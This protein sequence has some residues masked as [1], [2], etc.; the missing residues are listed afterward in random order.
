[1]MRTIALMGLA[2][3]AVMALVPSVA[4]C[5]SELECFG[6]GPDNRDGLWVQGTM[7]VGYHYYTEAGG[8]PYPD[9]HF[10]FEVLGVETVELIYQ[11]GEPTRP[12]AGVC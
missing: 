12:S 9:Q 6:G 10:C 5:G 3:T 4:A 8:D 2:L 11:G 1:M 7:V